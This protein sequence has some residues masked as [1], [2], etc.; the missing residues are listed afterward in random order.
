MLRDQLVQHRDPRQPLRQP[1]AGQ[2]PARIVFDLDVMVGLSP[3]VPNKQHPAS[4]LTY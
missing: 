4:P 2:H 1:T 3:I